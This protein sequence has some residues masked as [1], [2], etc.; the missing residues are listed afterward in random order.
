LGIRL[1]GISNCTVFD[2]IVSIFTTDQRR[3][4]Y[5]RGSQILLF[6]ISYLC[7]INI[8]VLVTPTISYPQLNNT[9]YLKYYH[10]IICS[11]LKDL[12]RNSTY[13][14]KMT[15]YYFS[16]MLCSHLCLYIIYTYF[17]KSNQ[18]ILFQKNS[19]K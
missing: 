11:L 18:T 15:I 19:K 3:G 1:L 10:E 8:L 17:I 14:Y 4:F 6:C 9:Y 2:F 5:F 7:A 13:L 12:L 16:L